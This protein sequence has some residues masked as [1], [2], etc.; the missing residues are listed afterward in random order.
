M[1]RVHC[2]IC[3]PF[4]V[5]VP[6]RQCDSAASFFNL[7]W[8]W[9]VVRTTPAGRS[10]K[11]GRILNYGYPGAILNPRTDVEGLRSFLAD[12]QVIFVTVAG[13]ARAE[14]R[15]VELFKFRSRGVRSQSGDRTSD[16]HYCGNPGMTIFVIF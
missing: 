1:F 3:F 10:W 15:A 13:F 4:C 6:T 14:A 8:A 2:L 16:G 12:Y 5:G 9:C 7:F 11:P